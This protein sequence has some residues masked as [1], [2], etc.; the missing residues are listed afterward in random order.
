MYDWSASH[1]KQTL[2]VLIPQEMVPGTISVESIGSQQVE[3][4]HYDALRI[5]STDLEILLYVDASRRMM[6]LD[7]PASK[8]TI[9]RE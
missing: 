9:Q 5:N 6:R 2:P 3:N 1:G 8:V 7:V 4:A